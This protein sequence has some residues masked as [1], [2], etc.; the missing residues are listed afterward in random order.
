MN[1]TD[2]LDADEIKKRLRGRACHAE[3]CVKEAVTS[4]NTV[5]KGLAE[6]GAP[7]GTVVIAEQQSAGKGRLGRRFH[8]PKGT[9]LYMSILLR[10]EFSA[11]ESL[12]I[13]TAA[14]VATANA[15]ERVTGLRALIKWVNDVYVDGYKVCGI[16]TEASMNFKSGGLNYAV[17]G[18]G[19]NVKEPEG[20]FSSDIKD[21]AGALYKQ[22]PPKNTRNGLAAEILNCFFEFYDKLAENSFME[23][24]KE[25]SLLTGM[26]IHFVCGENRYFGTVVGIDDRAR[27]LVRQESGTVTAFSAGEVS[28]EKDFLSQVRGKKEGMDYC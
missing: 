8:S 9:G 7:E 24:Y 6:Q 13:T 3:I 18:I 26:K 14:A 12:S 27:L 4:T 5:V 15:I 17:L 11:E 10:P 25:R 19:I 22:Q 23:E 1:F 2:M 28:I 21:I 20:G 16:L